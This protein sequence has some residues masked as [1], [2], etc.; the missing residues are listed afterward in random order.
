M[1]CASWPKRDRNSNEIS[2]DASW[3]PKVA[4]YQASN[5]TSCGPL[6]VVHGCW[7]LLLLLLLSLLRYSQTD[8]CFLPSFRVRTWSNL[9]KIEQQHYEQMQRATSNSILS[10]VCYLA[11][12]D[13]VMSI[14]FEPAEIEKQI[15]E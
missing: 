1:I 11:S 13:L 5:A 12:R 14:E 7:L 4:F 10:I 6:Y 15:D 9:D 3:W 2:A 8:I